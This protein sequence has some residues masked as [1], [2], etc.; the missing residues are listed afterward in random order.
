MKL[1]SFMG[2]GVLFSYASY[3]LKM[4]FN[5]F[6]GES[7]K[8]RDPEVVDPQSHFSYIEILSR[9]YSHSSHTLVIVWWWNSSLSSLFFFFCYTYDFFIIPNFGLL[10]LVL[11]IIPETVGIINLGITYDFRISV[12]ITII[13]VLNINKI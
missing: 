3:K 12:S 13:T 7:L 9:L 11:L 8:T 5:C 1:I 4:M 2:R 10:Y 6:K